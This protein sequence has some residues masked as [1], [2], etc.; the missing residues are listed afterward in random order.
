MND[1][2]Q[3]PMREPN[4]SESLASEE[5]VVHIVEMAPIPPDEV[6][7]EVRA[8]LAKIV[9][10][11]EPLKGRERIAALKAIKAKLARLAG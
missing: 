6:P 9:A 5:L 2:P 7:A 8:I 1:T 11:V 3:F 10:A 4:G